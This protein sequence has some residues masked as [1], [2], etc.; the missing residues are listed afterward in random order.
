M[1]RPR[2]FVYS[3]TVALGVFLYLSLPTL[4]E[5]YGPIV[6]LPVYALVALVVGTLTWDVL[7]GAGDTAT[8]QTELNG[9]NSTESGG[10]RTVGP[11]HPGESGPGAEADVDDELTQL[12][13]EL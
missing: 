10:E 9:A 3:V 8:P 13:N 7:T 5:L 12:R 4:R 6:N 11:A 1:R 2:A